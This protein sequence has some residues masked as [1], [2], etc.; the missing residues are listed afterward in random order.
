M[1]TIFIIEDD[2]I[3]ADCISMAVQRSTAPG[4][5]HQICRF[6][7]GIA[8]ISA[9]NE[10]LPDLIFLDVLLDGPNGFTFLNE[11]ISYG[12]AAKIPVVII[13]SL[14]LHQSDLSHY[15]VVKILQK[16]TM[17][18]S[19]ITQLTQELCHA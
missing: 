13:T 19:D 17:L 8:A 18:P 11:T 15:G 3:M 4:T 6:T 9:L 7:N 1:A 5:E 16:E 14:D 12:D 2:E 10:T